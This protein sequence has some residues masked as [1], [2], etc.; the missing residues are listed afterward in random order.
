MMS[1]DDIRRWIWDEME[2]K[3]IAKF[4]GA[5]GRIPNFV[6]AEKAC[7]RLQNI[8]AWRKAEVVKINPDSPQKEARYLALRS[9]KTLIMPTPRMREGF[10]I[11]EPDVLKEN[12]LRDA[13]TIRGA[14]R[15]GRKVTL[16]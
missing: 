9:G 8:S 12:L 5:K 7:L 11:L 3:G 4:P 13:S 16:D 2:R 15:H 14:F 10:L 1:K 6:G